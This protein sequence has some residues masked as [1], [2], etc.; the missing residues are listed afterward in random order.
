MPTSLGCGLRRLGRYWQV[1]CR[2]KVIVLF[3]SYCLILLTMG[4]QE[5]IRICLRLVVRFTN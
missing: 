3:T 4:L 2:V 1:G 5:G